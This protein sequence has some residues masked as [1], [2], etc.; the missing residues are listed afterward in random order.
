MACLI[1][2]LRGRWAAKWHVS[3]TFGH[4]VVENQ[5]SVAE[6][7]VQ[8][9]VFEAMNITGSFWRTEVVEDAAVRNS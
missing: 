7:L 1:G 4:T 5:W 3:D 8:P 2:C 9:P 6:V